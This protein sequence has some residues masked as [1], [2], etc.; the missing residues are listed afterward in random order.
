MEGPK[1][2]R[3]DRFVVNENID[4]WSGKCQELS[5]F[6]I[7]APFWR[8][9]PSNAPDSNPINLFVCGVY[10]TSRLGFGV[11]IDWRALENHKVSQ[12]RFVSLSVSLSPDREFPKSTLRGSE[13]QERKWAFGPNNIL[14]V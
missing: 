5:I 3:R 14:I 7:S 11:L 1:D 12:K 13:Q 10:T 9:V 8:Y 6:H 2:I 4:F